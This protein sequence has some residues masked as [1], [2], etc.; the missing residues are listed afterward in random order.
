MTFTSGQLATYINGKLIGDPNVVCNCAEIDTRRDVQG[1]VFFALRGEESDGHEFVDLAVE[2]G[3]AVETA[4]LTRQPCCRSTYGSNHVVS[5]RATVMDAAIS[6]PSRYGAPFGDVQ[7][8]HHTPHQ[9]AR[10]RAAGNF[11]PYFR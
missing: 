9:S 5:P 3:E 4:L 7:A 6:Y 1:K 10:R 8:P 2:G 11:F